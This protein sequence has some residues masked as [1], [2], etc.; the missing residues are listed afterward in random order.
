MA[1]NQL[2]KTLA[3]GFEVAMH[4]TGRY[5]DWWKGRRFDR[6]TVGWCCGVTGEVVRDTVQKVLVGRPSQI[7]TGAIPKEA[8]GELVTARGI[9]DLLD[10]IKVRHESGGTSLI[11]LKSYLSGR[12]KFQDE[13]LDWI[14]FDEEPAADIYTE[15][16]TRTNVG[17]GPVWMTFTP[18]QG[19]SEVVR[20][21]LHERSP[22]RQVINMTIDDARHFSDEKKKRI[23][24]SYPEHEKEARVK[25]RDGLIA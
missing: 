10:V 11:T 21:F 13:T 17:N 12:E 18:L 2:G 6:P 5:P 25:A 22:D 15:G 24:A 14:W 19:V 1:G 3:G 8:L 20:R 23:I 16:L 7:G 4:A 9:A